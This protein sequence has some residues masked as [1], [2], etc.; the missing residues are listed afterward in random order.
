MNETNI[1]DLTQP[2]TDPQASTAIARE[3]MAKLA[4][5]LREMTEAHYVKVQRLTATPT[6]SR[7][8]DEALNGQYQ[9]LNAEFDAATRPIRQTMEHIAAQVA[10]LDPMPQRRCTQ[11]QHTDQG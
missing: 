9:R 3:L 7:E 11:P 1:I 4:F 6:Y 10:L 2:V 8:Q 5:D